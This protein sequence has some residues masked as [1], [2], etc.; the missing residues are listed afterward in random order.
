ME[1][2]FVCFKLV[3]L[4]TGGLFSASSLTVKKSCKSKGERLKVCY[5]TCSEK[6]SCCNQKGGDGKMACEYSEE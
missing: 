1:C 5:V 6:K 4:S 2:F 3:L